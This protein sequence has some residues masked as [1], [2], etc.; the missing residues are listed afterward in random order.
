MTISLF[1]DSA[2][3]PNPKTSGQVRTNLSKERLNNYKKLVSVSAKHDG[4]EE[5]KIHLRPTEEE[6][7]KERDLN[8]EVSVGGHLRRRTIVSY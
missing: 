3:A 4:T 2:R 6:G 1:G 7:G 5:K 8:G